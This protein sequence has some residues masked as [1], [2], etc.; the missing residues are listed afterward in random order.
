[1]V[2]STAFLHE[3]ANHHYLPRKRF[4]LLGLEHH[5]FDAHISIGNCDDIATPTSLNTEEGSS[6]G[7]FN[8]NVTP[9][10]S[11][12]YDDKAGLDSVLEMSCQLNGNSGDN[13][14]S[15]STG[16]TSGLD[17]NYSG[18]APP[19][20]VSG[21][22]Y[23]NENGQMCGPYIQ[24]QLYQGLST[25][26]LPEDLHVYP[27]VNGALVNPV[28]LKYFKQF[29]DH[30]AT[31]FVYLGMG[32]SDTT[33]PTDCYTSSSAGLAAHRQDG[34]AQHAATDT[35]YSDAQSV[36]YSQM[37]YGNYGTAESI[38]NSQV[39]KAI[40]PIL[41]MSGDSSCWLFEDEEGRKHGPHSLVELRSWHQCGYFRHSVMIYHTENKIGPLPLLSV[42]NAWGSDNSE[43]LF[44]SDAIDGTGAM[45]KLISEISEDVSGQLHSG[46]M[47]AARRVALDEIISNVILEFANLKK[48]PRGL[49]VGNEASQIC[50]AEDIMYEDAGKMVPSA[51]GSEAAAYKY[52]S[53]MTPVNE[54]SLPCP[55]SP[56]SV[57][58]L[59]DFWFSYAVV[60]RFLFDRC[61]EVLWNGVFYDEVADYSSFWRGQK[62]WF[63]LPMNR[64]PAS[65]SDFCWN[66]E[67]LPGQLP[68]IE[69]CASNAG[70][71]P[72]F[73]SVRSLTDD[74][75]LSCGMSLSASEEASAGQNSLFDD[76]KS[77][78]ESV[79]TQLHLS[80]DVSL[81]EYLEKLIKKEVRKVVNFSKDV[82]LEKASVRDQRE[83]NSTKML[84]V[85]SLDLNPM[86]ADS[87]NS[88]Q[89]ANSSC[90]ISSDDL[91]HKP[92]A[93]AFGRSL[94]YADGASD[95]QHN[96]EPTPPGFEDGSG[97]LSPSPGL[98]FRPQRSL[99]FIPKM[100]EYVAIAMCRQKLHDDVLG[101][102]K[103]LFL[104][105]AVRHFLGSYRTSAIQCE[106]SASEGG[107]LGPERPRDDN[108]IALEDKHK[109]R[110]RKHHS[111]DLP[112]ASLI[113]GKCTYSR[114][115]KMG[116]KKLGASQS[117]V[118]TGSP[119]SPLEKPRMQGVS[120]DVAK[121]VEADLVALS[122]KKN[123]K[124]KDHAKLSV[125]ARHLKAGTKSNSRSEHLLAKK[126]KRKKVMKIAEEV[127]DEKAVKDVTVKDVTKSSSEGVSVASKV[128]HNVAK[129]INSTSRDVRL[130]K[131]LPQDRSK[132]MFDGT[133]VTKQKRKLAED[134]GP[135]SKPA[136]I[137]KT[138]NGS[139]AKKLTAR[140]STG[141]KTNSVKTKELNPCPKSHGC[142]RSSINGWEWHKWSLN[143]SHAERARVRGVQFIHSKYL[144]CEANSSP[145]PN[146]KGLSAR[147]NRAKMRNL[148]AAAEG[149]D[150]LK[151]TQLKARKKR[152]RFQRSKIHDWGLVAME[153]IEAED[154]VI[155]YVGELI[156]PRIS[157]I[158]ERL[159]EKMGI[160]SSYLFRLDDGYVVDAT[161]RGGIARFI[162]HSCE[163]NCYTKVISLDGEKK[164][165][166]YAKRHI[167]AGEEITYN[168]K[169]PLEEKKIPCNCGSRKCRGSLN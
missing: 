75:A 49:K 80:T 51:P 34:M 39:P 122:P 42:L 77:I 52:A 148:L 88:R 4:K 20:F 162:N 66:N 102:C 133:K 15:C 109:K 146:G 62:I 151:A 22:M 158:R 147:T 110:S 60:C 71:P 64:A 58:S 130:E 107:L 21:W 157:D 139:N 59:E 43:S 124:A 142:A 99:E 92:L 121:N 97:V 137:L 95:N 6:H 18:C 90:Q 28:P 96:N 70:G 168:Y 57:G 35:L 45:L 136:K 140:H 112:V 38:S 94:A 29:P 24:Q 132:K 120:V 108:S 101:E 167:Y 165:F 154:F 143:A 11:S 128:L 5:E 12:L 72:G 16:G 50:F 86:P 160:G 25:G 17:K 138:V 47:K 116:Q 54:V 84:D 98:K 159:Y 9:S 155:E 8:S 135:A 113:S 76:M 131:G 13:A 114:K 169:F 145:L 163:P 81:R 53:A 93:S 1:M 111:L 82:K 126:S 23:I 32:I 89:T 134:S 127:H 152:L 100:G 69:T 67:E 33:R 79:E 166:I 2:S 40:V 7:F 144:N 164:I 78:L 46:I 123:E 19:A 44:P 14:E 55:R 150:L 48:D 10:S 36:S 41:R 103:S 26:F 74:L 63:G 105:D 91:M 61:M 65:G 125:K 85:P 56:K 68:S 30:V 3:H 87:E 153:P 156:R 104:V 37:H 115:K 141:Q 161:K 106:P 73:E 31:G 118:A 119:D 129:V 83:Q 149:A 117:S 27:V